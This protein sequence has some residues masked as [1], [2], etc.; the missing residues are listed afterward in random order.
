MVAYSRSISVTLY[1]FI[2]AN[3]G[4]ESTLLLLSGTLPIVFQ[5]AQVRRFLVIFTFILVERSTISL[6]MRLFERSFQGKLQLSS[7]AQITVSL[8]E[9]EGDRHPN[10]SKRHDC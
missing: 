3:D 2:V 4:T 10:N 6:W 5:G 1:R 7:S 9:A 8:A